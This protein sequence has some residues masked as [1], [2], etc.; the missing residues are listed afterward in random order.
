METLKRM[1]TSVLIVGAGPAG[2]TA[3]AILA[4]NGIDALTICRYSGTANSP[5]AHITNQRTME[6]FRDMGIEERM[7]A[8]STPNR[9][10]GNT[11]WMTS[12]TGIELARLPSWGT[13]IDR[14][15]DYERAS[16]SAM[17]NL[18]QHILE[19]ALLDAARAAGARVRFDTVLVAIRQTKDAVYATLL[20]RLTGAKFEVESEYVIGADGAN[21]LV[22]S[23]L[24]FEMEGHRGVAEQVNCWVEVDLSKYVS[25]RPS[26]LYVIAQPGN[27][28]W[29]GSGVWICVK[30]WSEWV[31][32]FAFRSAD[33]TPDLSEQA[34]VEYARSTIGDPDIDVKVKSVSTWAINHMFAKEMRKGR[35]F[36]A[37]DA[38]HRHPPANGL[39]SNTSI[40]DSFNLAWKLA[41][42]LKGQASDALLDSY[43]AERQPVARQVVERANK[44]VELMQPMSA[45]FGFSHGQS[46]EAGWASIAE[47]RGD[48]PRGRERRKQLARALKGLQHH[49]NAHGVE[50]GQHYTSSA[51]VDDGTPEFTPERDPELYVTPTTRPGAHVPH[52]WVEKGQKLVSTLDLVGKNGFTVVTGIGGQRWCEA[53]ER[54]SLEF[55]MP[56]RH[57][58]IGPGLD[59]E[60][61]Y[62]QWSALR[63]IEENGCLLVRP[64]MHVAFRAMAMSDRPFEDLLAAMEHIVGRR[65]I[66]LQPFASHA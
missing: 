43:S 50:L 44:S 20:D 2:L 31:L 12:F 4:R 62:G 6:V 40:Q 47:L 58:A 21:S 65:L 66:S 52:A 53:A 14:R 33:G 22:A 27:N 49:F 39:G 8:L 1:K 41:M 42:V 17:C 56:V 57:V 54:L 5:R 60:D 45:A 64:D 63:E 37:G 7:V 46:I 9:L 32:L 38:A 51:I 16:P 36:I 26:S 11:T 19:P 15:T 61:I 55:G 34:V 13:G 24:G 30:P 10:M 23:E 59:A 25:H 28:F 48:S 29:I 18:P 3:S 35:A